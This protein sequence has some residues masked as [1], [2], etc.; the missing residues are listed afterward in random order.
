M[1]TNVYERIVG[2]TF[3]GTWVSSGVTPSQITSAIIDRNKAVV[4]SLSAV[5]SMNGSFY[6]LHQLPTT[7]GFYTNEWSAWINSYQYIARQQI[8]VIDLQVD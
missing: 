5:S 2:T 7:P 3:K 8:N 4:S 1:R 6:S